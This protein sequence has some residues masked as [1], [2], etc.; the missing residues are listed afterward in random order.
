MNTQKYTAYIS[1][2]VLAIVVGMYGYWA[3]Q[4]DLVSSRPATPAALDV[5]DPFPTPGLN[6]FHARMWED[7]LAPS[8][9]HWKGL[10]DSERVPRTELVQ[11]ELLDVSE[12][13]D[14]VWKAPVRA[15]NLP[16]DA[17]VAPQHFGT[18][19]DAD[20]PG[21]DVET[22]T[23]EMKRLLGDLVDKGADWTLCLPVLVPG[24]PYAE[25]REKRMRIRYSVVTALAESNYHLKYDRRMTYAVPKIYIR[26]MWGWQEREIVVPIKLY[27]YENLEHP[28]VKKPQVLVLWI[29]EN[30][31]GLRPLL[32]LHRILNVLFEDVRP[33]FRQAKQNDHR[34]E[35]AEQKDLQTGK[36]WNF[37]L[38]VIGPASSGTLQWMR[39]EVDALQTA[40]AV[41]NDPQRK[42]KE[43]P[44]ETSPS[45]DAPPPVN[46]WEHWFVS[47]YPRNDESTDA[48]ETEPMRGFLPL[49]FSCPAKVAHPPDNNTPQQ[50]DS[51]SVFSP[52]ATLDFP[53]SHQ[54]V[55][56]GDQDESAS[57]HDSSAG[58]QDD[59]DGNLLN[60][61]DGNPNRSDSNRSDSGIES[62]T[63]QSEPETGP[64]V[65]LVRVIGTDFDLAKALLEELYLRGATGHIVLITEHDT[66]Y[67][68]AIP[69][70]FE[71]ARKA[72]NMR[73]TGKED[74]PF[75]K[76][77]F[78]V[79]R[80]LRGI[81]GNVPGDSGDE[82][83][84]SHARQP[85]RQTSPADLPEIVERPPQGRS[86]YDYLRRLQPRIEQL[87]DIAAIGVVGSDVYDKLLVLRALKPICPDCV[88]FTTDLDAIYTHPDQRPNTRNL[89]IASHF[90]LSLDKDLQRQTPP[91]RDSY[92]TATF[93]ATRLALNHGDPDWAN[94]IQNFENTTRTKEATTPAT[95]DF[96]SV[97]Y[98]QPDVYA[99]GRDQIYLL[100]P[101]RST[102][103]HD[104][105]DS[106]DAELRALQRAAEQP[107]GGLFH[108]ILTHGRSAW[109]Y[110]TPLLLALVAGVLAWTWTH[111]VR[112]GV[113]WLWAEATANRVN[114]G[115]SL[116]I[117][118]GVAL[119]VFFLFR[120]F[121]SDE[122]AGVFD[123]SST[124]PTK[125][126]YS[127]NG[128]VALLAMIHVTGK[129]RQ[130]T[131][132]IRENGHPEWPAF[133]ERQQIKLV[134]LSLVFV[135][136]LIVCISPHP[137][138]HH[139]E[140]WK[141]IGFWFVW[142]TA[143]CVPFCA[144]GLVWRHYRV[145]ARRDRSVAR[146]DLLL[147]DEVAT[148]LRYTMLALGVLVAVCA[149]AAFVE[150]HLD[151]SAAGWHPV[152]TSRGLLSRSGDW[153]AM[154]YGF[155]TV[156]MLLSTLVYLQ[157]WCREFG[158]WTRL[159]GGV[160]SDGYR[161]EPVPRD[162][163]DDVV[164]RGVMDAEFQEGGGRQPPE[165]EQDIVLVEA[166][167]RG[168]EHD[169][170]RLLAIGDFT[171]VTAGLAPLLLALLFVLVIGYHPWLSPVHM[172]PS[173]LVLTTLSAIL[174]V[175]STL[176]LRRR[177]ARDR[178]DVQLE[179]E[180]ELSKLHD[181]LDA[182]SATGDDDGES[183]PPRRES[184]PET[185]GPHDVAPESLEPSAGVALQI[186][187]PKG[188]NPAQR[189]KREE[190]R[191]K[192]LVAILERKKER[193]AGLSNGVFRSW[194]ESPM[195]WILGG[196]T[197]LA[198]V[199]LWIRWWSMG[200]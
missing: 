74:A 164:G 37:Q 148:P 56:D 115:L 167:N 73:C 99:V 50:T 157:F 131:G 169:C 192:A 51:L 166:Y 88:F 118:L 144:V 119:G 63:V 58:E 116:L 40:L 158:N 134:L 33:V 85:G 128:I 190:R 102:T 152:T 156:A 185:A 103:E 194:N 193:V 29:N 138:D 69:H 127:A 181:R 41:Y 151:R 42:S 60:V 53:D 97:T 162:L 72:V 7:P 142:I 159:R 96:E 196:G 14:H 95:G 180:S 172:S 27:R 82:H 108:P 78:T 135:F 191:L 109:H 178:D 5:P 111:R 189:R 147:G 133:R 44:P 195:G 175:V 155:G 106:T 125:L 32:A 2:A 126:L 52:R 34:A 160:S 110:L 139:Q 54:D 101:F 16:S 12:L 25:D 39:E 136:F 79:F 10:P 188:D 66:A 8:Y 105:N 197:T 11:D 64:P 171:A 77:T 24:G 43:L 4:R 28:E 120:G 173:L 81:D 163:E 104:P 55:P 17:S 177:F 67:G 26:V 140:L 1:P 49:L 61:A 146:G 113:V 143:L 65:K 6:S 15:D 19:Q 170:A 137:H 84:S 161:H 45:G 93:L 150:W 184:V 112:F 186:K 23:G 48:P 183:E 3:V 38:A 59:P 70:A 83:D 46:D 21:A 20:T 121:F 90:G 174:F 141:K 47:S 199:D 198:L 75:D 30:E 94:L 31:L 149:L 117:G 122:Q 9:A 153:M 71:M 57:E 35:Q 130:R 168:W 129:F 176:S 145:A 179:F 182:L 92:Q 86:Q 200:V 89:L 13:H 154:V 87:D 18:H 36:Q 98:S 68:R 123:A 107:V 80:V 132:E 100:N 62:D 124:W 76:D 91:F 22:R 114:C 187:E 165:S